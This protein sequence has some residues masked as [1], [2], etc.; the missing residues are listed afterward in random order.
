MVTKTTP[1]L[2]LMG[3]TV[4]FLRQIHYQSGTTQGGWGWEGDTQGTV[5]SY[6]GHPAW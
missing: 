2:T 5:G 4:Q 3:L 1:D 6:R